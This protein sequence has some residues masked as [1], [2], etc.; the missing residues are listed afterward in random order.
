MNDFVL[1]LF[2]KENLTI[3][4]G[5]LAIVKWLYETQKQRNWETNKYL[6]EKLEEF[7]KKGS[8]TT[9]HNILDY[10]E[11]APVF[12]GS[13]KISEEALNDQI[14]IDSLV[15]HD[16]KQIFTDVEIGIRGLFDQYFDNLTQLILM[17]KC[18]LIDEKNLKLLL[19]YYI[20]IM[21]GKSERKSKEYVEQIKK[22][23]KFYNY[24]LVLE[25][26]K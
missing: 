22:Y 17:S 11:G 5:I 13:N 12:L 3:I 26:I 4:G 9:I 20:N 16:K 19:Q 7:Q 6:I 18:G 23:L 24:D 1:S 21:N 10:N 15:T 25:F 14:I 8:T 2:T